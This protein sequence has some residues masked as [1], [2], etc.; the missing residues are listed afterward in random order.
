[1][2]NRTVAI[3]AGDGAEIP[4]EIANGGPVHEAR[5]PGDLRDVRQIDAQ[6]GGR[7]D[8]FEA[9]TAAALTRTALEPELKRRSRRSAAMVAALAAAAALVLAVAYSR[10]SSRPSPPQPASPPVAATSVPRSAT[11]W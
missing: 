5:D 11:G 9:L 7:V 3:A 10:S 1:V 6:L 2:A 8:L 4:S